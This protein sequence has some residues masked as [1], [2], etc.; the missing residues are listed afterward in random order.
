MDTTVAS[1]QKLNHFVFVPQLG[2]SPDA[3]DADLKKAYRKQ[4]IKVSITPRSG[5]VN[6]LGGFTT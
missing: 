6:H 1:A 4:A 5:S 2:V 3:N